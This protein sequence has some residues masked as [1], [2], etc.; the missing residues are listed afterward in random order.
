M[1]KPAALE[2]MAPRIPTGHLL[3]GRG[4]PGAEGGTHG[5]QQV[6]GPRETGH[7][8]ATVGSP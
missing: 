2:E 8:V 5:H 3:S 6:L 4:S 1:I 7:S